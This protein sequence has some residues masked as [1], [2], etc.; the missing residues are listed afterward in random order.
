MKMKKTLVSCAIIF[1]ATAMA[2][3]ALSPAHSAARLSG[4]ATVVKLN[5]EGFDACRDLRG[6]RHF[7]GTISGQLTD[8]AR[9][10]IRSSGFNPFRVNYCFSN[11]SDC[12]TFVGNF[13]R[14]VPGVYD[15]R[16][17]S[18]RARS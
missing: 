2:V 1:G 14:V 7:K 8:G 13:S 6:S 12:E 5:S 17:A 3:G 18:C 4:E 16:F 10:N 11:A 15:I 9:A